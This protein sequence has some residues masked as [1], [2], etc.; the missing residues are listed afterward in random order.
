MLRCHFRLL[1][2]LAMGALFLFPCAAPAA[3]SQSQVQFGRAGTR[4]LRISDRAVVAEL[5]ARQGRVVADYGA[6]VV[7]EVPESSAADLDSKPILH[8][9]NEILLNAGA[10]DTTRPH[11]RAQ[12]S[13]RGSFEGK[14]LHL[15]QFAGP[16]K[17]EWRQALAQAAQIVCYVPNNAFLVYGDASA[18][19]QVQSLASALPQIQWNGAYLA[20]YKIDPAAR[21]TAVGARDNALSHDLFAVQMVADETGNAKTLRA[22]DEMRLGRIECRSRVLHYLNV[23][24]R[25]PADRLAELAAQPDIVSIQP[26]DRPKTADERQAQIA[27]GN[28]TGDLPNGPGYLAWLAAK[29]FS[30]AQFN[31]S[32]FVID[33]TDS[34]ID[35][36]TTSPNHFGLYENGTLPGTSRVVYNRLIGSPNGGSTL[37]G[38]DGHGTVDAH[39]I[40]GYN[41]LSGAPHA[42]G[43]GYR[44]GLGVAPFSRVGS[45][46][47]F[48]DT[49]F[50]FP[51]FTTLQSQ[52]YND[53]ARISNNSWVSPFAG[54]YTVDAQT[55]D[56]LVR[57]AQPS[58]SL[59]PASGNQPMV[60]VFANGNAGPGPSS[61]RSPA[62]AKNVISVGASEN[63]HAIGGAD[64]CGR[65]DLEA[66]SAFDLADYSSRGPCPDGRKKPDLVAPGTHVT[67]GVF[68]AAS[69]D[70]DGTADPCFDADGICAGPGGSLFFPL[71]QE[72]YSVSSGTSHSAAA[73]SGGAALIRQFFINQ[74]MAPPSPAMTKALLMNSASHLTG[75]G[76]NDT[77]WSNAQGMG[78]INM[79]AA[80][81]RGA[82]TPTL[83]RDQLP[84]DLFTDS[85]QARSFTGNVSDSGKPFRVTLA[86]TDAPGPTSGAAYQNDLDLTVTLNG[87]TY[88]GNVFSGADSTTGGSADPANNAESVFLPA[89][90]TGSFTVTVTAA[91]IPA[92]GV[93]N[94]GGPVDQDFALVI[95]NA[96]MTQAPAIVSAGAVI[97]AQSC[98]PD[99]GRLDPDEQVT[100]EFALQNSGSADASDVTATL[101]SSGGVTSP[102]VPQS[103]GSMTA[104]GASVSRAF[105]FTASGA[106]G[107]NLVATLHIQDG[108]T[109]LGN[110]V[111]EFPLGLTAVGFDEGFEDEIVPALP[112]GWVATIASGDPDP[113]VTTGQASD[114]TPNSMFASNPDTLTDN[115]IETPDIAITSADAVLSF[116]HYF[117][118]ETRWDGGVLEISIAG[119]P[120][121]DILAAGGTFLS[122]EYNFTLNNSGNPLSGRP[123]WT[124]NSGEFI[125]TGITFP[126]AAVG[127]NI[128]LRWRIAT[129][130]A[131]G[132]E[133]WYVD[134]ISI[135]QVVCCVDPCERGGRAAPMNALATP[136][137]ICAGALSTLSA[138]VGIGETIDWYAD[139]CGG[140]PVGTGLQLDVSPAST[141]TYFAQARNLSTNCVSAL[142]ATVTVTVNPPPSPPIDPIANMS[143]IC[144]GQS[145]QLSATAP[146][147]QT[148]DWY[149]TGC[150][151]GLIDDGPAPIVLPTA[152]TT[153]YAR[154]R[155]LTTGCVSSSC[156]EVL[157]T[158]HALPDAP[159]N[160]LATPPVVCAGA[161]STLTATSPVGTEIDWFADACGDTPLEGGSSPSVSPATT[162]SYYAR[163][164]DT[165]TGCVSS[166][167]A[168]VIVTVHALP[169]APT[170]T[171]AT[172]PV[173][174]AGALSILTATSPVDT[175]VDWFADT[176]DGMP[177]AGGS[178]PSVS[179]AS[180]TTYYARS[181]DTSTGCISANCAF[182]TVT[183]EDTTAPIITE[184]AANQTGSADVACQALVPDFTTGVV[185]SDNC[186]AT[187]SLIIT[188]N[189]LPG[190]PVGLGP[191]PISLTV[192]DAANNSAECGAVFTVNDTTLP[193][194]SD[195]PADI[196]PAPTDA[197]KPTAVVS[198]TPPTAGDNCSTPNVVPSHNPGDAFPIGI[199]SVT[200]T[201]TDG[202]GNI[203]T[204][205]FAVTIEDQ[206][207]PAIQDCPTTQTLSADP[208]QCTTTATWTE[209]TVL[210]NAPGATISQIQGPPPGA[211]FS[212]G[213]TQVTY[214]AVDVAGL[215]ALCTFDVIVADD[216]D[217]VF[218]DCPVDVNDNTTEPGCETVV[219]WTTPVASDNC[220]VQSVTSS[221]NPGDVFPRGST[222]VTYTATDINGRQATCAFNV[223]VKDDDKPTITTC[224]PDQEII[225]DENCEAFIPDFTGGL[226][227]ADNCTPAAQLV[228]MQ[229]PP[230]GTPVGAGVF[231]ITLH[232][233]DETNNEATCPAVFTVLD[234]APVIT[235]CA[236]DTNILL[237]ESCQAAI[238]DFSTE[239]TALDACFHS[240]GLTYSQ[241][242]EAGTLIDDEPVVVTITINDVADNE[243][244]CQLTV[245]PI[246]STPPSILDCPSD[247]VVNSNA[248]NCAAVVNWSAPSVIDNCGDA[249]IVQTEGPPAGSI[250]SNGTITTITYT[251]TDSSNLTTTCTFDVTVQ[252]SP[253]INDDGAVNLDDVLPF[254]DVLI[255]LTAADPDI[256]RADANCDGVADGRDIE[257]FVA[258]IVGP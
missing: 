123:A 238:P 51:N 45:S 94:F 132:G 114:T 210:D 67:G 111:F 200:Y 125:T 88:R 73:V 118:T 66:D 156:E 31:A 252:P 239:V 40:V 128:K 161:S 241:S 177:V 52:A 90:T 167:C 64:G 54:T 250:F 69:P 186:S 53:N 172:P 124:G 257:F 106:C 79:S 140:T 230:A 113:W 56:A 42:D 17:R 157:V 229:I 155:D 209:P 143:S 244:T 218:A 19:A 22:I 86:W 174:C 169:D 47:I 16:V 48:D 129:D 2:A 37:M 148:V 221:H 27:A 235:S 258:S 193:T 1:N 154:A 61:V 208:G 152:S 32:A 222:L 188:Q 119:G 20:H 81:D 103:Y 70:P 213:T 117:Q 183:V 60:V 162:T 72:W 141:T 197:G 248:S 196:G 71:G 135:T 98:S 144:P 107:S 55:F 211:T 8:R 212:V 185:A 184:C 163:S 179:P 74:G 205:S 204:C 116:R 62:T 63:V 115:H 99:N 246:D 253:D 43:S 36:G 151:V 256:H 18:I 194:F 96:D 160:A 25:L 21:T 224:P 57:D 59:H 136:A 225:A 65:I 245:T 173:I 126:P 15:V 10:L 189:P 176:C 28:L 153:Y 3:D 38:C 44:Y 232:V 223:N 122:G 13:P 101:L 170:D 147:G 77:L 14:A 251:A 138:E 41:D 142:C 242:P 89:G 131:S 149:S 243:A 24:V 228:V 187:E 130:S 182:V 95:C 110:V 195:C 203:E 137:T 120:F 150:G 102:S 133:G 49:F 220:S 202:A 75:L 127:Q 201:A 247:L 233:N 92:D 178:A 181:R 26:Y 50:T 190:T 171:L 78:L 30:Q 207:A 91:N 58:G 139:S 87:V 6:F 46:V 226:I 191:T 9:A 85:G 159:T 227:A 214:R 34:G 254:V 145:T 35:N 80:F 166:D 33:V 4:K 11:L 104:G 83:F 192:T 109:D 255:D 68:Q 236:D 249:S 134:T 7:I 23:I 240:T 39:I 158:V 12:Q 146:P 198:W 199:T 164:R 237:N 76:A 206:E 108:A 165:S 100:I 234:P 180:T 5:V 217:P 219:M 82:T 29:G 175:E 215:E 97:T 93:P 216:E 105:T 84:G 231:P 168:E 121:I 112:A